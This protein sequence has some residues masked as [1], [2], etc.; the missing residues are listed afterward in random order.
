MYA[1]LVRAGDT[2]VAGEHQAIIPRPTFDQAHDARVPRP[3]PRPADDSYLLRDLAFC[4]GC[5]APL[6]PAT[7]RRRRRTFRYY[8]CRQRDRH[9]KDVCALMPIQA[10]RL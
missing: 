9:G 1:G 7:T 6:V 5:G 3:T 2:L 8:R 4:G 10:D